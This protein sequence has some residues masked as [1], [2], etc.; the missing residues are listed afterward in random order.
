MTV[1]MEDSVVALDGMLEADAVADVVVE[2][3][4]DGR[5]LILP[6]PK[7]ADYTARKGADRDRW[8]GGMRKLQRAFPDPVF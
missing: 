1:D 4:A 6:H 7:V 2:G 5:F 3:L 8:I